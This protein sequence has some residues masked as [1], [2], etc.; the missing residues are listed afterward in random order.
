MAVDDGGGDVDELAVGAAGVGAEHLEGVVLVDAVALHHDPFGSLDGGAAAEGT[1]QVLELGEPAQDD[2]DRVLELVGVGV[3][4]V[5][6]DAALGRLADERV[7]VG[8]EQR[9]HWARRLVDDLA[10]QLEGMGAAVA[11]ADQSDIGVL[12]P[13]HSRDLAHLDRARDHLMAEADDDPR[14]VVEPIAALIGDQDA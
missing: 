9:D 7:I 11:Q 1:L 14:D 3:G 4:D 12:T 13:G 10:D 2:L 6:E 5:G 8:L